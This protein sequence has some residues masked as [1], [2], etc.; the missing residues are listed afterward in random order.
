MKRSDVREHIF[1]I[2]FSVEFCEREEFQE[3]VNL[4]F[5]EHEFIR[6]KQQK[7]ISD[8]VMDLID[9]LDELDQEIAAHAKA[10]NLTRIGKAELSILRLAI[11]EILLDNN[12]PRKV[13][14]SEAVLLTK[15]YCNEKAASFINGILSKI[16]Q[17]ED[18]K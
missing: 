1:K 4:Y 8:K 13:P 17:D 12:V 3:Q 18:E 5:Q 10:W 2:L 16:G 9:H 14:I 11:Y 7:E 15:K 6:E